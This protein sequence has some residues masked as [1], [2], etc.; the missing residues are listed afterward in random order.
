MKTEFYIFNRSSYVKPLELLLVFI[1]LITLAFILPFFAWFFGQNQ[2][3]SGNTFLS[4][5]QYTIQH[6][7]IDQFQEETVQPALL[8]FALYLSFLL[9]IP[10]VKLVIT[11]EKIYYGLFKIPL[12]TVVKRNEIEY[13][14][15]ATIKLKLNAID[16]FFSQE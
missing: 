14:Q 12:I 11:P 3:F 9:I 2:L 15:L 10:K 5:I 8:A 7:P 16:H 1:P 13:S 6:Y 4:F